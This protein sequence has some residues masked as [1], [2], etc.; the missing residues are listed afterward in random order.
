MREALP[1]GLD[2]RFEPGTVIRHFPYTLSSRKCHHRVRRD[3][4]HR[5]KE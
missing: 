5:D 4:A 2:T 1:S 3:P